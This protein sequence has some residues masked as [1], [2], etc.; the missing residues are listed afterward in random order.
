M[1]RVAEQI[2]MNLENRDGFIFAV[3]CED[4]R[5]FLVAEAETFHNDEVFFGMGSTEQN[6]ITVEAFSALKA[7]ASRNFSTPS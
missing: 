3:R 7:S 4:G 2:S 6:E 1:L 5:C